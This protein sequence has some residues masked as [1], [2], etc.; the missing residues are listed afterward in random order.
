MDQLSRSEWLVYENLLK[1]KL[2]KE[3][4]EALSLSIHTVKKHNK[5]IYKKLKVRNRLEATLLKL[6]ILIA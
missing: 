2:D 3:I 4:A 5:S 1:G 6:N